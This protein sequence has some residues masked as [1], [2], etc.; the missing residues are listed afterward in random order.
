[1]TDDSVVALLVD[2]LG[3][4]EGPLEAIGVLQRLETAVDAAMRA[5]VREARQSHTWDVIAKRLGV[6]RQAVQQRF[7]RVH[8]SDGP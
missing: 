6:S 3:V 5:A 8:S 4:A 7:G 1:M 2:E